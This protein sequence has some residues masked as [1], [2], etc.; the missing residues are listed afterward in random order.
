MIPFEIFRASYENGDVYN[1]IQVGL[2]WQLL[3]EQVQQG[4]KI[5]VHRTFSMKWFENN[6]VYSVWCAAPDGGPSDSVAPGARPV[7]FDDT[8]AYMAVLEANSTS[9]VGEMAS[10]LGQKPGGK[11]QTTVLVTL[12]LG[13]NRLLIL[14]G[15]HRAAA[16]RKGKG[17]G[18]P[19]EVQI[20]EC[21][22]T[23]ASLDEEMLP[24][25][26][27]HLPAS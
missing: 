6:T 26:R 10:T 20:V 11:I 12:E 24:D 19:L 16:I 18:R 5:T 17:D 23:D 9:R 14:D 2:K 27:L 4:A 22:I 25:L 1:R 8:R 15:N 21:R 3:A 7:V 13:A